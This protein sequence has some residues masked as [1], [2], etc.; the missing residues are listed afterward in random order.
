MEKSK[1]SFQAALESNP[2]IRYNQPPPPSSKEDRD[3]LLEELCRKEMHSKMQRI[4]SNFG[5]VDLYA[6]TNK[7]LIKGI[8]E[9]H[10]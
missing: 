8:I 5:Y 9:R 1:T 7:G 3:R 6:S 2:E 10:K 4:S